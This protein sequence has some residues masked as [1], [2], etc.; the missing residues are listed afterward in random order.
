MKM[1]IVYRKFLPVLKLLI[2]LVLISIFMRILP[3]LVIAGA[4]SWGIFKLVRYF[5]SIEKDSFQNAKKEMK[6]DTEDEFNLQNKKVVDVDYENVSSNER[7][8]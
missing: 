7:E 4:V 1:D 2:V 3:I 5:K 8:D 6:Y